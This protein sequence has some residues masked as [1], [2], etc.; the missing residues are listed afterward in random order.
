MELY[1]ILTVILS[2]LSLLG[3]GTASQLFW[4]DRHDKKQEQSE[5]NKE[6][7]KK[8]RQEELRE[9]I[10][11]E[12]EPIRTD[13]SKMKEQIILISNGTQAT[14]RNDI[15]NCYY[16]C[17]AKKHRNDYDSQDFIDMY[18]EYKKLGGN[19]FIDDIKKRFDELDTKEKF[20]T[21]NKKKVLKKKS[22][23]VLN[24]EKKGN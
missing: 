14:L 20:D 11:S 17:V 4:K 8:G 23:N 13:I 22:T 21:K 16:D 6:R 19:S 5:E 2:C 18:I 15:K 10:S 12:I 1:Q 3:L 7:L 24:E 9:V